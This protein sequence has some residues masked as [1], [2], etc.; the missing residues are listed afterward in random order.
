MFYTNITV[1][2]GKKNASMIKLSIKMEN[3]DYE[4]LSCP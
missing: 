4:F 2:I 3:K 1:I